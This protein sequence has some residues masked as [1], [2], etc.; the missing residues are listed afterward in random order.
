MNKMPENSV[1]ERNSGD[2]KRIRGG[3]NRYGK[4]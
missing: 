2:I 3:H 4:K 1:Q